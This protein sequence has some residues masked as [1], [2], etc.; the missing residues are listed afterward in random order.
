MFV[1]NLVYAIDET[2]IGEIFAKCGELTDIRLVK[3]F[4]GKSKGYAYVEFNDELSAMEA[5]KMDRTPIEGR[6]MF[7][8]KCEDKSQG[9]SQAQFKV[10][11]QFKVTDT[12]Q[13]QSDYQ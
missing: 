9:R 2:K 6:P 7:V 13:G 10:S 3:S 12:V 1:S 5:M 4:T 11:I 8:S